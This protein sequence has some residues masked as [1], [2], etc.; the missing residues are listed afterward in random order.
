MT[1]PHVVKLGGSLLST[2]TTPRLLNDWFDRAGR[3]HP[4]EH[5]VLIVGGGEPVDWLRRVDQQNP[6]GDTAA[7][8]AAIALMDANAQ[9]A[10]AWRPGVILTD[11]WPQLQQRLGDPGDTIFVTG[12]FLR[13]HEPLSPGTTLPV[14]WQVTS[15]CIAARVAVL[16][17]ARL[18]LLKATKF[19]LQTSKAGW[20]QL[21]ERGV[22]DEFFPE[23]VDELDCVE[24]GAL[25]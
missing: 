25:G 13:N 15:D 2:S 3:I 5:R 20:V 17:D 11:D 12:P 22:V 23:L 4:G 14:G 6:L 9:V 19:E 10:A 21:A 7:H 16:L 1:R 18:T 24:V 8:W